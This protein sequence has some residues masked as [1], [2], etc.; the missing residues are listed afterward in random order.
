[1][2]AAAAAATAAF[3]TG[4]YL[5]PMQPQPQQ[6]Q[7][8]QTQP[9]QPHPQLPPS[10]ATAA[11]QEAMAAAASVIAELAAGGI[12]L[13]VQ[14]PQLPPGWLG[15]RALLP[16]LAHTPFLLPQQAIQQQQPHGA[17]QAEHKQQ[18]PHGAQQAEH[19]QQ[20]Q[21]LQQTQRQPGMV[22]PPLTLHTAGSGANTSAATHAPS[23][24]Q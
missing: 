1:M 19:H 16:Q 22:P 17:Q 9:Q 10:E 11:A 20:Q 4:L 5:P 21:Q 6:A 13:P 12:P 14:P 18:Q 8:P 15:Q 3:L 24:M 23:A 2:A 7:Q